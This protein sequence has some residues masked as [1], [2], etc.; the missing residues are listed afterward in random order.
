MYFKDALSDAI[1]ASFE[2]NLTRSSLKAL[3]RSQT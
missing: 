3:K 1:K 2:N